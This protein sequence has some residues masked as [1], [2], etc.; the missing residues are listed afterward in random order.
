M[1]TE[2]HN[3]RLYGY[4]YLVNGNMD[5]TSD[6]TIMHEHMIQSTMHL[7]T[8]I[9]TGISTAMINGYINGYINGCPFTNNHHHQSHI[10]IHQQSSLAITYMHSPTLFASYNL[11]ITCNSPNSSKG[12]NT[13]HYDKHHIQHL[14]VIHTSSYSPIKLHTNDF[15][16]IGS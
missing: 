15:P 1:P 2:Y 13:T 8:T 10:C 11:A 12:E 9:S 6:T 16:S 5:I 7:F 3:Q 4:K 14:Q